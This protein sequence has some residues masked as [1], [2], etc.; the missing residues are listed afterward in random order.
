MGRAVDDHRRLQHPLQLADAGLHLALGVL[1]GVVVAV[2]GQVAEGPGGLDLPRDLDPSAGRQILELGDE[3]GMG[4]GCEMSFCHP[5]EATGSAAH[6]RTGFRSFS[7]ARRG[8][9]PRAMLQACV[10]RT[11][12]TA[13]AALVAGLSA[14]LVVG[15]GA[16][17]P[18]GAA[19]SSPRASRVGYGS[20]KGILPPKNPPKS[21][22]PVPNFYADC[23]L[24]ALDPTVACN[25]E[26]VQ[27]ID[28]ARGREPLGPLGSTCRSSS[29]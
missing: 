19:S 11:R 14:A 24:G 13:C 21:L 16:V 7:L 23:A 17:A 18:A 29:A 3:P 27:A 22:A 4:L 12:P 6:F 26:I 8:R 25:A 5:F 10:S 9:Y 28:R 20:Q 15:I 2:L 1:G